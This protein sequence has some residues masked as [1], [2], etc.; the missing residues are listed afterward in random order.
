MPNAWGLHDMLGN[1]WE[2]VQDWY[3]AYPGGAVTDPT[4]PASGSVRVNRGESWCIFAWD[5]RAPERFFAVPGMRVG[6]L[7]FR[8]LRTE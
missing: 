5:C 7:G 1:V 4:G 3:G 8:L 6:I 2:W